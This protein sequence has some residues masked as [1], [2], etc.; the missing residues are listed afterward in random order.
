[1]ASRFVPK[2]SAICFCDSHSVSPSSRPSLSFVR[3]SYQPNPPGEQFLHHALASLAASAAISA[4]MSER[5]AAM[6]V[7]SLI[8]GGHLYVKLMKSFR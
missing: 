3:S 1:M 2:T 7:C 5:M 6:A 4:S 8:V